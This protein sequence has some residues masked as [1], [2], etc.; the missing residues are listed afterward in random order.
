MNKKTHK[1]LSSFVIVTGLFTGKAFSQ[2]PVDIFLDRNP[3]LYQYSIFNDSKVFSKT[4]CGKSHCYGIKDGNL[5]VV[6]YNDLGQLGLGDK[7]DRFKWTKIDMPETVIEI[8]AYS[9]YGFF[10]NSNGIAYST[11][12]NEGGKI[13]QSERKNY[14]IWTKV[15]LPDNVVLSRKTNVVLTER[16]SFIFDKSNHVKLT[17]GLMLK[18][19]GKFTSNPDD[20]QYSFVA[21]DNTKE[22]NDNVKYRVLPEIKRS[23]RKFFGDQ[24]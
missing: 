22:T 3:E 12:A 17:V 2:F 11:G 1:V 23:E 15:N 13:G 4:S 6:G 10:I 7:K 21:I 8:A 5:Y 19:N 20:I 14:N 9:N 16:N 18:S 24:E